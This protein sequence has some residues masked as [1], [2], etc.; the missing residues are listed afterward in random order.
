LSD[1]LLTAVVS[2]LAD[3]LGIV[4]VIITLPAATVREISFVV[5]PAAVAICSFICVCTAE[6]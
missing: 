6:V 1:P 4:A 3:E 5:Q 2:V